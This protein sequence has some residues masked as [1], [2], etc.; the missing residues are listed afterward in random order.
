MHKYTHKVYVNYELLENDVLGINPY[1]EWKHYE[2]DFVI[3]NE[4][5]YANTMNCFEALLDKD[6]LTSYSIRL[7]DEKP[8]I[9]ATTDA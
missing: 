9:I 7:Y 4:A 3:T 6:L 8:L 5:E 1:S 2:I